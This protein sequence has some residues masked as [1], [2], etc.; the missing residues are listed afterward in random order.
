MAVKLKLPSINVRLGLRKKFFLSVVLPPLIPFVAL[1][2][3]GYS[4]L[5][6]LIRV[7]LVDQLARASTTTAAKLERE[8]SK[9]FRAHS[10]AKLNVSSTGLGLYITKQYIEAVGGSVWL[11]STRGGRAVPSILLCRSLHNRVVRSQLPKPSRFL[12]TGNE[13]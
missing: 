12:G 13:K 4:Q 3:L 8:F 11:E 2:F 1:S 9:F 10:P 7:S 5:S 6:Q